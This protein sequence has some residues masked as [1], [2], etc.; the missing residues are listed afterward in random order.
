MINSRNFESQ[1]DELT[2]QPKSLS[3]PYQIKRY[4]LRNS[5]MRLYV[6]IVDIFTSRRHTR[7]SHA[8]RGEPSFWKR[9]TCVS[10][11]KA[12]RLTSCRK[13]SSWFREFCCLWW[14]LRILVSSALILS[15]LLSLAK[16]DVLISSTTRPRFAKVDHSF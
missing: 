3:T 2:Y 15:L 13:N 9:V 11:R 6:D 8:S 1:C 4:T 7:V 16:P 10:P 14:T 5:T 12:D